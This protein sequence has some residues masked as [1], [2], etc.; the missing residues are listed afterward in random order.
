[1]QV[2]EYE[3]IIVGSGG[4]GL[5]AALEASQSAKTA[6]LSK[7]YPGR[8]TLCP[9]C[10]EGTI[11]LLTFFAAESL[12][13]HPKGIATFYQGLKILSEKNRPAIERDYYLD[14]ALSITRDYLE[15]MN[16][17]PDRQINPRPELTGPKTA[18]R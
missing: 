11:S 13:N 6:V 7:L 18:N 1:M 4:A 17:A 10:S 5:Y 14:E 9:G 3:A 2:H 16:A 15:L 12:R 8:H